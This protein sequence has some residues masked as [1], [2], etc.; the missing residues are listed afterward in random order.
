MLQTMTRKFPDPGRA[1]NRVRSHTGWKIELV[2]EL[3]RRH[4][5]LSLAG[6]THS[7]LHLVKD[8]LKDVD[9][10]RP[11][12]QQICRCLSTLKDTSQYTQCGRG[13]DGGREKG[14]R[15]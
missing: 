9:T 8:C 5:H 11:S 6:K 4:N 3:Q 2:P 15:N 1:M 12:A 13:R 7:M 10:T 14:G